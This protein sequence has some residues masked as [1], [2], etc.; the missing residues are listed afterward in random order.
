MSTV[1]VR[2]FSR[3]PSAIFARVERGENIQVT[4]EGLVIAVLM[5]GSGALRKGTS[6]VGRGLVRLKATTTADLTRV[7][8]CPVPENVDPLDVLL[9]ARG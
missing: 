5:P 4:R 2:E 8:A 9:S 6:P 1:S 7:A 3:N